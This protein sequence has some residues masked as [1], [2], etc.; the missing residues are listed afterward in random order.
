MSCP[1]VS[2][3]PS[4]S[5]PEW[6]F[7]EAVYRRALEAAARSAQQWAER[8]PGELEVHYMVQTTITPVSNRSISHGKA[9]EGR[10]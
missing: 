4:S 5:V 10:D 3:T 2:N 6:V 1:E 9:T 8:V 7:D